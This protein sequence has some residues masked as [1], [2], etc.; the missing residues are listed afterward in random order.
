[1]PGLKLRR[2]REEL[3]FEV[4]P[5]YIEEGSRLTK[6]TLVAFAALSALLATLDLLM[7]GGGVSAA[8]GTVISGLA[9]LFGTSG[10][11]VN[12]NDVAKLVSGLKAELESWSLIKA[13]G[14]FSA[15]LVDDTLL[16]AQ[17]SRRTAHLLTPLWS[18]QVKDGVR[19]LKLRDPRKLRR[20]K[21]AGLKLE[22]WR[23]SFE[24]PSPSRKGF[25]VVG[26]AHG[27]T[28]KGVHVDVLA[29]SLPSLRRYL[30]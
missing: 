4:A 25:K 24:A 8:L 5:S 7:G 17:L 12:L 18:K 13:Q 29:T 1:M 20:T 30:R 19:S 14:L 11:E 28:I 22:A 2:R 23:A 9:L 21:Q 15:K 27:L 16:Y 26:L 3:R 6:L 10:G